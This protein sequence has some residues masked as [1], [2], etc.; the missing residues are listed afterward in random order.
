MVQQR[1][2]FPGGRAAQVAALALALAVTASPGCVQERTLIGWEFNRDGDFEGWAANGDTGDAK[3][4]GGVLSFTATGSDPIVVH[5]PLA[6]AI[7]ATPTGAIRI[8]LRSSVAARA[9]FFWTN[10]TEG[11]YGGFSPGKQT[12][13]DLQEGWRE[14]TVRPFWQAEARIVQLRFDAPDGLPGKRYEVDYIRVVDMGNEGKPVAPDWSFG[15]GAQ[16]WRVEGEGS[17]GVEGGWLTADLKAGARLVSPPVEVASA[18]AT[19]LGMVMS[20]SAGASGRIRW[21]SDKFNGLRTCDFPTIA[22]GKPHVYNVLLGVGPDAGKLIYLDLEPAAGV[23]AKVRLDWL[24]AG[25]DPMGPAEIEVR[26]FLISDPLPRAGRE[27]TVLAQLADRGGP[28][29][30]LKA[31]LVLPA[32][33]KLARGE[34]ATKIVDDVDYFYPGEVTWRVI[35]SRAG[36]AKLAVR[37]SGPYQGTAAATDRFLPDLKLPRADYVP[38]PKPVRGDYDVGIY[39][40]PGWWAWER[41]QPIMGYPERKPVLGWYKEGLPEVV[42]WQIKWAAEN[43]ATF[44][45]YDWYWDRGAQSLTH[46]LDAYFRSR[47]HGLVKFCLLWANHS[48]TVHT[49]EDNAKVCQYWID[50]YFRRPDYYKVGGRPLVVMFA[51]DAMPRDLGIEGTRKCI[52]LWHKMTREAGVGEVMIAGCGV[53]G[54]LDGLAAMGFDAASGYNWPSCGVEGR[55]YVPYIEVVRKQLDLWWMPMATRKV[56]PVI[57]PTSPGWDSRPWHGQSAF[58]LTD[59]TPEAFEEHL[60]LARRCIDETGQPKVLL[61]EAWNEFGEGSYCEPHREFGFG[62]LDAIRRVFCPGAGPH[63][64]YGPADV[65]LGPYDCPAPRLNR[66]AWEFNTDGDSEGWG[67]MMGM[68]DVTVAGGMLETKTTSGDPAFNAAVQIRAGKVAAIEVRMAVAGDGRD[69]TAQLFWSSAIV[70]TS[71]DAS[72]RAPIRI[73]G[74]FRVVRFEVGKNPLWRQMVTGLRLDPCGMRGCT[75]R[76]DW[77]RLVP[78][79]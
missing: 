20:I 17:V 68:A 5:G 71:E 60:R 48:P 67:M 23:A 43:G 26:H 72:C 22:D 47:Y 44:F 19:F 77:V 37:F 70:G 33:V 78:R 41:W 34:K 7:P 31:E 56:L 59:R 2:L 16:G 63:Q 11:K 54:N 58:V 6:Q 40:F 66:T 73:D 1:P 53:P 65:G 10:A 62:H 50:N 42:D 9:E 45:C 24:K 39:Y 46:G 76:M 38:Q 75:V 29:H 61:V 55:N 21:A 36:P 18:Q 79:P 30:G 12:A 28:A 15:A 14:Y 51:P 74:Q 52:E 8:R 13:F 3:V 64:D 49:P 27:C 57:M 35:A 25:P 69:D 32:G 4:Q